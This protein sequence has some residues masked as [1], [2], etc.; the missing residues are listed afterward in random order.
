M[1]M[2]QQDSQGAVPEW[3]TTYGIRIRGGESKPK[4]LS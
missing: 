4:Y 3:N 1:G 2:R